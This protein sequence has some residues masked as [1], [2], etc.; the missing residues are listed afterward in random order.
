MQVPPPL[1]PFT[2]LPGVRRCGPLDLSALPARNSSVACKQP[3]THARAFI[4][5]HFVGNLLPCT[6]CPSRCRPLALSASSHMRLQR[7]HCKMQAF[8]S[9]F[10]SAWNGLRGARLL[11][12]EWAAPRCLAVPKT[13]R[14]FLGAAFMLPLDDIVRF[15]EG[16]STGSALFP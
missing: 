14:G 6:A 15:L 13:G 10:S 9:F 5:A 7:R 11:P 2:V 16:G 3:R 4:G 12:H 1:P 8:V